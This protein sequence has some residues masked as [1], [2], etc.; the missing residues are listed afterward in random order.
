MEYF[1]KCTTYLEKNYQF[2]DQL[3]SQAMGW[4]LLI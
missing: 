2:S 3:N 4:I 1:A